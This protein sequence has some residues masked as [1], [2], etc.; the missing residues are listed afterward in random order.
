M[1]KHKIKLQGI[2]ILNPGT[3]LFLLLILASIPRAYSN[4]QNISDSVLFPDPEK[5]TAPETAIT[6]ELKQWHKITLTIDGPVSSQHGQTVFEYNEET[7]M[8]DLDV[9]PKAGPGGRLSYMHPNPFLDYAMSV[10]F[11]HE[12][13]TPVYTVPGYFA[14]DG[15]AAETSASSGN[16]WRAHLSP[17]KTGGWTWEVTFLA[18]VDVS[19]NEEVS[20]QPYYPYHGL[21]GSFEVDATDKTG[22]DFRACGRLQYINHNYLRFAGNGQYF[23]KAGSDSPETLLAYA[24]FDDT[25]TMMVPGERGWIGPH[26]SHGLHAYAAHIQDW[27]NGDPTWKNG[28][29]KG[30]IGAVNYLVSKEMNAISF[31][32]HSAGGDGDNVWPWVCRNCKEHYSISKLAQWE[33]VFEHAQRNGVFL[34]FKLQEQENDG[35][36]PHRTK[37]RPTAT[38]PESLDGGTVGK[39]RKLYT[40]ELIA[41]FGHHLALNWNLGE[42]TMMSDENIKDWLAYIKKTDPYQH[43]RVIHTPPAE[44]L[45]E[46]VYQ[47]LLGEQS[48]LTGVSLQTKYNDVHRHTLNWLE[49][50][51]KAGTT[52]AVANDEQGPAGWAIPP[53]PGFQNWDDS[54][55]APMT[56]HDIRKYALWGN[57]MAGGWGVEYY[58]GYHP[59]HNDLVAEDFRSRDKSWNYARHALQ[60]FSENQVP[61]REMSNHN[62]LVGN[63][64]NDNSRYCFA[65]AGE[66][67][68]V[69]LPEG[70]TA[71]LDLSEVKG[72]FT[73]SWY[74]PRNGGE[75][76]NGSITS[77]RGGRTAS[78]GLSPS[79]PEQDWLIVVRN[80]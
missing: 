17:D 2:R 53:D 56:I 75:L 45:Q 3:I 46:M 29:G 60:F 42:E 12:S 68:L 18:G 48:E 30:I 78:L 10:T 13:G 69:Y 64:E 15:N 41:R 71:G 50:S 72:R 21:K 79:Y 76:Q 34:H 62:A 23:L 40:R 14:A 7:G 67:Y 31:L 1:K 70:G 19:V 36:F 32:T 8:L 74:D 24:D 58:F 4:E 20:G 22:R 66:I 37:W 11:T 77:V 35:S 39:E 73:I 65:K 52:W 44:H 33:I 80:R 9:R 25:E 55:E 61:F 51:K 54:I 16:K 27:K 6:G 38:S 47:P 59:V 28:K 43:H 63:K 26:D 57:L 49:E 5:I